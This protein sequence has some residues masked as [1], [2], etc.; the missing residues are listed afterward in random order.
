MRME[1]SH[2]EKNKTTAESIKFITAVSN[3]VL[4]TISAVYHDNPLIIIRATFWEKL[5]FHHRP[6]N[7]VDSF[8]LMRRVGLNS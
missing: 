3:T 1:L 4:D 6:V 5:V 2:N 7:E 8:L